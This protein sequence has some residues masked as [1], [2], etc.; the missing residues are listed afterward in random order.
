MARNQEKF[1]TVDI[2]RF[3]IRDSLE[4]IPSSLDSL[5]EDLVKDESFTFPILHQFEPY[6]RLPERKKSRGL[7]LLKR[8]GVYPYEHFSSYKSLKVSEFP[9]KEAFYSR[10]NEANISSEDHKHG[11]DVF[12][13]F[14]CKTMEDYMNL[15]CAL[16]VI[17]LAEIFIKYR[18]MVIH[19]F[20][21]DPIYYLGGVYFFGKT[22]HISNL[23]DKLYFRNT[24]AILRR[25]VENVL[26]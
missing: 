4:H 6:V 23:A 25:D 17:L 21:L 18:E 19:H 8:K 13:F 22:N 2:G 10:L 14:R 15:Y 11:K 26:R 20:G 9:P 16:D 24:W 5:M 1:R 3:Q 7:K 12:K